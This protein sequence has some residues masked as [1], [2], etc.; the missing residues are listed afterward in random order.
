V[1]GNEMFRKPHLVAFVVIALLLTVILSVHQASAA[2]IR[3]REAFNSGFALTQNVGAH[4]DWYD[5][6]G[7]PVVTGGSG[8]GGSVGL[9]PAMNIFTW[10]AHPFS[11]NATEFRAV[12]VQMDFQSD[13]SAKF[14]DDR[15]GWMTT[16]S[17]VDSTNFFGIQLDNLQNGGIA[18]YWR[19]GS[20][21]LIQT[22]IVGLT[23]IKVNTWYRFTGE[24]TKLTATSARI[25]VSLVEMDASGNL[26]G[27]SITGTVNDTSVWPDGAPNANYFTAATMWPAYK[28]Y[29]A[30]QGFAD[31]AFFATIERF[32]FVTTSDWHTSGYQSTVQTN[33][34]QVRSWITSPTP[35]M[36]APA[37]MVV[38]GDFPNCSQTQASINTVL[39]SGYLWYPVIGNHEISDGIT[40]FNY[41]RDTIVPS[42]PYITNY[43]PT[44]SINTS[45]SWDY[46]NAHFVSVNAYWDGTTNANADHLADGDIRPP[47]RT[48]INTDLAGSSA[49]HKFVFVHEPAYPDTRHVGDSLDKYPAN[50]DTFIATLNSNE[51]ET[52]FCGHT[53]YYEHDIAP[54]YPL[55]NLHQVTNGALRGDGATITYTLVD[56][57]SV[58]YKVY[59]RASSSTPFV[60]HEQW[61]VQYTIAVNI[62]G[63]G[64]VIKNPDKAQYNS[65]D[66]VQLAAVP[67]AGY[68]FS[69]WSGGGC[70]GTGTCTLTVTSNIT[71]TAS[72]ADVPHDFNHDT[73]PDILWRN[74]VTGDNVIWLMNGT[75][76]TTSVWLGSVTDVTWSIVG[77]ADFNH[78]TN[79]DILWRNSLSGDNV[80]WLMNGTNWLNSVWLGS[81]TDTTWFIVGTGDFNH[82]SSPDILWRNTT[83]GDNV[84]WLMNGTNWLQSVWLGSVS[85]TTWAIVGVGDFNH[86]SNPDILWRNS[87]TGDNVIWLMNGTNWL[88]SVWLGSVSDITW[89]IVGVADFNHDTNPDIL[90]RNTVTGD[91]VIWLMDGTTWLN[92]IWLP[93]VLDV[94]WAIVGQ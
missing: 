29:D 91:N 47:L 65:G 4:A 90:W 51:V 37:F 31:N 60:L 21:T 76:W 43:G 32:A 22:P 85:D 63:S 73:N 66:V 86:D 41:I 74:T 14:H 16:D 28:N 23:G 69:G 8:V 17:S 3:I 13:S 82:D 30:I 50:R 83:T 44:G 11:W 48:W 53:H 39:G 15:I 55:G 54:E 9:A 24:I 88:N 79:P 1:E 18:T 59:Y 33:L 61:P 7:G 80:I 42:L 62:T 36:P 35:E 2:P 56:G 6:G 58:T 57:D 45:Y 38:T 20:G 64:S 75:N 68:T 94:T 67:A 77:T 19:D 12:I 92:S 78:D 72:F 10:T 52:L 70:S 40:N 34:Q 81:V 25:N 89:S 71:V 5:D 87:V 26:T 27:T 49:P 46:S 84:I 93:A